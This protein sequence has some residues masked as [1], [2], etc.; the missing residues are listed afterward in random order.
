[1]SRPDYVWVEIAPGR[2]RL[3]DRNKPRPAAPKRSKLAFPMIIR[4]SFDEP[5]QSQADGKYYDTKTE[6][7]RSYR[8]DGNPQG[9]EYECVGDKPVE[10]WTRPEPSKE[11]EQDKD[12]SISRALDEMGY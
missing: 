6:L 1:M 3:V 12:A 10:P 5:V 7:F 9:V 8:A 11:Y 2:K 4:D